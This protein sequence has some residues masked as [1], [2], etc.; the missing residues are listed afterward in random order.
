MSPHQ[1][2]PSSNFANIEMAEAEKAIHQNLFNPKSLIDIVKAS[3]SLPLHANVANGDETRLTKSLNAA[4]GQSIGSVIG[5]TSLNQEE[6]KEDGEEF[7]SVG[8]EIVVGNDVQEATSPTSD[9][10][11]KSME[12][13]F[14]R[15]SSHLSNGSNGQL[16]NRSSFSR[17]IDMFSV[18]KMLQELRQENER[19]RM[20]V[21]HNNLSM[22]KQLAIVQS[23]QEQ[24]KASRVEFEVLKRTSEEE[25]KQLENQ[26]ES[27]QQD[28]K[29]LE[30]QL[31]EQRDQ[32]KELEET[33][34][35][36]AATSNGQLEGNTKLY[37]VLEDSDSSDEE[38]ENQETEGPKMDRQVSTGSASGYYWDDLSMELGGL[39]TRLQKVNLLE[40]MNDV[41]GDQLDKLKLELS[42]ARDTIGKL[43]GQVKEKQATVVIV[44]G[45]TSLT[46]EK[47]EEIK[48]LKEE[49]ARL[50][51]G[52]HC[53]WSL[54]HRCPR[55]LHKRLKRQLRE[56]EEKEQLEKFQNG[57]AQVAN[58][59]GEKLPHLSRH[60]R[61]LI[62]RG[63]FVATHG[64]KLKAFKDLTGDA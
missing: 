57:G 52:T 32:M 56:Q 37:P 21:E 24:V 13:S 20:I 45:A 44:N 10:P 49:I 43:E 17:N 23:W 5:T 41:K 2:R 35:K 6:G 61:K 47:E 62:K 59:E 7:K 1:D 64:L 39:M 46:D 18:Q 16:S 27:L 50:R 12:K 60:M 11:P 58:G 9:K 38:M 15:S 8:T 40:Q 42:L 26:I 4:N 14:S 3:V 53:Q 29:Q 33:L 48:A 54:G 19:L 30:D 36:V 34:A 28:K 55:R 31:K 63:K 51:S 22:K 25:K